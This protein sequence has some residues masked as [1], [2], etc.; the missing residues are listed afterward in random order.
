MSINALGSA[1]L[2]DEIERSDSPTSTDAHNIE[3]VQREAAYIRYAVSEQSTLSKPILTLIE[4]SFCNIYNT[5]AID[6]RRT[7]KNSFYKHAAD[8]AE[9]TNLVCETLGAGSFAT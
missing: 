5:S 3:E 2:D 7:G 1:P 4:Q 9:L 8:V 6:T